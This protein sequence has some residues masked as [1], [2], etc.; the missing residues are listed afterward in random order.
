MRLG[1][2]LT[3]LRSWLYLIGSGAFVAATGTDCLPTT[4]D[5]QAAVAS[6]IMGGITAIIDAIFLAIG[7]A[8]LNPITPGIN[9]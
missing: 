9:G 5:I 7:N 4:A 8:L 2:R 3:A 6:N 1:P